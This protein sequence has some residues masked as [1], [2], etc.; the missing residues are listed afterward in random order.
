[1]SCILL[2]QL[3]LCPWPASQAL[4]QPALVAAPPPLTSPHHRFV[5][6]IPTLSV[7]E[8]C[9]CVGVFLCAVR[10]QPSEDYLALSSL[11]A[12]LSFLFAFFLLFIYCFLSSCVCSSL[13]LRFSICVPKLWPPLPRKPL[14]FS[15]RTRL[16][17]AAAART[18]PPVTQMILSWCLLTSPVRKHFF[19]FT[20]TLP[21]CQIQLCIVITLGAS[22]VDYCR[23]IW[24]H[25]VFIP[26]IDKHLCGVQSQSSTLSRH[27]FS[28]VLFS[29][30]S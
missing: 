15:S 3:L 28:V 10:H 30:C 2:Q 12:R 5:F 9:S 1:M 20:G 17:G 13:L 19:F 21:K 18:P 27:S 26:F 24:S 11:F 29:L 16:E 25:L 4:H 22:T 23:S 6:I 7:P 14:V 8:Q